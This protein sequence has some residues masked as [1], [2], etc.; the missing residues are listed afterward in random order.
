MQFQL[1]QNYQIINLKAE[2]ALRRE[3]NLEDAK[4]VVIKE[5]PSLPAAR[6]V[7]FLKYSFLFS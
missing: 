2:D 7:N 3:K 6:Q 1:T 5:D 4:K